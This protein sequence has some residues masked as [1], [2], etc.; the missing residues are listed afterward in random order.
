MIA[1]NSGLREAPPTKKPSTSGWEA[2]S[3]QLAALT[4]PVED[5]NTY[6]QTQ[7]CNEKGESCKAKNN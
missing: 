7:Q 4:E 1:A 3:R 6:Y 2:S 5:T